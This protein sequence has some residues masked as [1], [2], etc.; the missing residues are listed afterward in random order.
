MR[1]LLY[2]NLTS[3]DRGRKIITSSE[4]ADKGGVHSVVRR[5][6]AYKVVQISSADIQKPKPYLYIFKEKNSKE[7][8][9]YFFCK[10]KGSIIAVN[11]GNLLLIAFI[12][13]LRVELTALKESKE[14]IHHNYV[15][16]K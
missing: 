13:T 14:N 3:A 5:H 11:K 6:F 8:R 9:E 1:D 12:H 2:K 7:K 15:E 10:V 4:V 16:D